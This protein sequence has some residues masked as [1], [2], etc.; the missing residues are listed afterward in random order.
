MSM[1]S[2]GLFKS[3]NWAHICF[4]LG[5]RLRL[6]RSD[7]DSSMLMVYLRF[8]I[9]VTELHSSMFRVSFKVI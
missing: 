3:Q 6:F 7:L 8:N 1:A 2:F 5:Y 9:K 4:S